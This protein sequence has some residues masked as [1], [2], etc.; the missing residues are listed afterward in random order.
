MKALKH[1][2]TLKL[3]FQVL[4]NAKKYIVIFLN[5]TL[6]ELVKRPNEIYL[7]QTAFA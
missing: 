5:F 7:P 4:L 1:L 6:I 2:N 3:M